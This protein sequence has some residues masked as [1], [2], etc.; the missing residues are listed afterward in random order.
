MSVKEKECQLTLPV[1]E[2]T[3]VAGLAGALV[4]GLGAGLAHTAPLPALV[5]LAGVLLHPVHRGQLLRVQLTARRHLRW[6]KG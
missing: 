2:L 3:P 1:A 6:V 4:A 5:V